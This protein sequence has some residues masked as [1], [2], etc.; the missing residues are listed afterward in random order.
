ML[1]KIDILPDRLFNTL[2]IIVRI[3]EE[4]QELGDLLVFA[5]SLSGGS[6]VDFRLNFLRLLLD[7]ASTAQYPP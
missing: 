3:L 2:E 6:T 5:R 1:E 7:H 4:F